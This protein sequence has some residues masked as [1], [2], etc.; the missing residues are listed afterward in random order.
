[1]RRQGWSSVCVVGLG[2]CLLAGCASLPEY[3][4]PTSTM[5]DNISERAP[6]RVVRP[7]MQDGPG[8]TLQRPNISPPP[9]DS[10]VAPASL[11]SRGIVRVSVRAWVNGRPIF[12]DEL[13]QEAGPG[14][15]QAR[16]LGKETEH[17]NT[18]LNELIDRE[19]MYQDAVKKLEKNNSHT[20]EKMREYVDREFD[21]TMDNMRKAKYPDADINRLTPIMRRMMERNI[22]S[23][24]YARSRILPTVQSLIGL[25]QIREYYD[26][27][28]KEFRSVDR[29]EWQNVFIPLSP[30][31][32][33][34]DDARR[35]AEELINRCQRND[36]FERL[37]VYNEGDSKLRRGSGLGQKRGEIR[38]AELEEYLFKLKEGEIGPVVAFPTGVHLFRVTK[39]EYEGQLPL[40][41][42]IQKR[43]RKELEFKLYQR[44]YRRIARE[45]RQ[46]AVWRIERET[47]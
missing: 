14:L 37:M 30:N 31:L 11:S 19:L 27:H 34:V 12:V 2:S 18:S 21:K 41:V 23:T 10:G 25:A 26:E 16:R 28:L 40:N 4:V 3:A 6:A 1:M 17:F 46:R 39:R 47:Q 29:I 43:I 35:F 42:E 13:M 22:I 5:S 24:E 8:V 15:E 36:D 32:P 20:L 44:E 33:T 38:P 7:Q 45:L 9:P